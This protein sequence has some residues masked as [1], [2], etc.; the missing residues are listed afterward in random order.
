MNY[1]LW[2]CCHERVR[3]DDLVGVDSG[4]SHCYRRAGCRDCP[5]ATKAQEVNPTKLL[6]A[7]RL[8]EQAREQE[9]IADLAA[10]YKD[11]PRWQERIAELR[12]GAELA[13]WWAANIRANE[14]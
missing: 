13:K 9:A 4:K 1:A 3:I 6:I 2:G 11:L 10:E 8:D 5:A 14:S 12:R 7:Q